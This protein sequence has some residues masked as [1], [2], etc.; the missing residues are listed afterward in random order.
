VL[1]G[2]VREFTDHEAYRDLV[3]EATATFAEAD[4]PAAIRGLEKHLGTLGYSLRSLFRDEQRAVLNRILQSTL[5]ETETVYRQVY[6]NHAPLLRFLR[7]L[8]APLRLLSVPLPKAVQTAV[9]FVLN[10]DLRRALEE[11]E[12]DPAIVRALLQEAGAWQVALDGAG[13]A[14]VLRGRIDRRAKAFRE[15]PADPGRLE[16]LG[17]AIDLALSMPF[18]VDLTRAQ[19]IY[20]A[21]AHAALAGVRAR[22]AA[23]DNAAAAWVE[24]FMALGEKL[25]VRVPGPDGERTPM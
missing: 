23:G 16:R 25:R 19:N 1:F 12:I 13:L 6:R 10:L 17:E 8:G 11:D 3:A 22:A 21:L 14:Y 5:A 7:D 9:E 18:G 24:R 20:Y 4:F 2:G 15:R